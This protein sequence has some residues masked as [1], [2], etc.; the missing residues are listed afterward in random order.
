M[1]PDRSFFARETPDVARS[2]LGMF[3][4]R[5]LPD[6][7]QLRTRIVEC[8]AYHGKED[9]A[10]H[11]RV[12]E[13]ARTAPMFG[14]PGHAYV[15]LI[16]GMY[17]MLNITTMPEGFP[18]AVLLRGLEPLDGFDSSPSRAASPARVIPATPPPTPS[19]RSRR[20]STV[21]HPATN[22]PGKLTRALAIDR[23][24]NRLDL[25]SDETLWLELGEPRAGE[26]VSAGPRVGI[27]YATQADQALP[28]RFFLKDNPWVSR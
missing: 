24:H 20:V 21:G 10:C 15:Y 6:G 16:Y 14:P 2:L 5:R 7:R 28:W 13:T 17:E 11:A 3:L 9:S 18:A 26:V 4:L 25:L 22:G 1:R 8:E 19:G 27:G 23:S 12:G